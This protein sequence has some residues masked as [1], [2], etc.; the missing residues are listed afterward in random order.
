M[1]RIQKIRF[2]IDYEN[3]FVHLGELFGIE[4]RECEDLYR[5]KKELL[6]EQLNQALD[7]VAAQQMF[8]QLTKSIFIAYVREKRDGWKW[9]IK[10]I[11]IKPEQ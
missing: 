1:T 9:Q 3:E 10:I 11:P 5:I 6:R 4:E 8:L 7:E 2:L